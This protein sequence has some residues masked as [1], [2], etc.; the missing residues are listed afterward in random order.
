M[1]YVLTRPPRSRHRQRL[2]SNLIGLIERH[3][4]W[5]VIR[6]ALFARPSQKLRYEDLTPHMR[7]DLNLLDAPQSL[8]SQRQHF[9]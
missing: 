6:A 2:Q 5:R 9:L 8:P 3:G 7:R 4:R 1:T